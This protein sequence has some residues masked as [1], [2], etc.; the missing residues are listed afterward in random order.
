MKQGHGVATWAGVDLVTRTAVVVK[1]AESRAGIERRLTHEAS[2]LRAIDHPRVVP[3]L[4]FGRDEE[5]LYLVM[6]R[7]EGETLADREARGPLP[8][9]DALSVWSCVLQGLEAL[10]E[11]GILHRDVKPSNVI[12]DLRAQPPTAV[13]IDA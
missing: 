6:P 3:L 7:V 13:L 1:V 11:H 8:L 9:A 10:H 2:V 12:I 5:T 4:D